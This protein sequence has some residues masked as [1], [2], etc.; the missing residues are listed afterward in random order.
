MITEFD[1]HI[2]SYPDLAIAERYVGLR[3]A[4][5]DVIL[6]PDGEPYIYRWHIFADNAIGN[7]FFHVQVKS[8]PERPFHDHPWDN[9]S[10]ILAG[11][12]EE[13]YRDD[14][15]RTDTVHTWDTRWLKK[16]DFVFR[17]ATTAHRLVLPHG[18]KYAMTLFSTG[19]KVREWGF[20]YPGCDWHHN[21]R[22]VIDRPEGGAFFS[23]QWRD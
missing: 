1:P 4:Q 11:G 18:G 15:E 13:F 12:Y 14:P 3:L 5:P 19:P 23:T 2:L 22:H 6:A 10:L 21:K 7:T 9:T 8:D 20:W 17:E 16:G